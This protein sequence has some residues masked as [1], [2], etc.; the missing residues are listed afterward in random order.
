[1]NTPILVLKKKLSMANGFEPATLVLKNAN[2]VNVFTEEI[3]IGD[4]ALSGT[5]I[6]G[7]GDYQGIT[8]V[9]CT[10]K[11]ITPGFIDAHMHIESSM[12]TP[13][14]L[15]KAVLPSG[16]TTLIADPH[17]LVNVA[18]KN[19]LDY[20]V[21]STEHL[22]LNVYIML[23]S[24]VPATDFETNGAGQFT[25]RDM[26][27]YLNHPRILGLGEM[28]SFLNVIKGDAFILE[29]LSLCQDKICDGHAPGL[30]G[31]PLQA[32]ALAGVETDHESTSFDEVLEKLRTGFKILIR[33]GSAAKN[34]DA[35]VTGL[36]KQK[37]PLDHCLFCT[38]D[39]HLEDIHRDG[40]IRWNIEKAIDL[41][42]DPIKAIKIATIQAAQAYGLKRLGA[43]APGYRADLVI[44]SDLKSM[45]VDAVY[46]DGK[47]IDQLLKETPAYDTLDPRLLNS[48]HVK[49]L[50]PEKLNFPVKQKDHIIG[51][52]PFQINTDHLI[53]ALPQENGYFMPDDTYAKLCVIERHQN[54]G[55]VGIA[56]IKG[57]GIKNGAI[58]TT[59]A[60][61]SHNIIVVGSNDQDILAAVDHLEKIQG[62]YVIVS[63]GSVL[64]DVPLALAG[65][66]SLE[67]GDIVQKKLS[68]LITLARELGVPIGVDPF[69]TLSFMALPVIPRLRLTDLGLFDVDAFNFVETEG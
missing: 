68:T 35:I 2:I 21:E 63:N 61:D 6:V 37:L 17:E 28:M 43:I 47:P 66:I 13:L 51:I 39:K 38:D 16:T 26:I 48:V 7:T 11:F 25:A 18:G 1:M 20:V 30:T 56:P 46:K 19:G 64:G 23:P 3:I 5:T 41:G 24:S 45:T 65:L 29:K 42:L 34:L 55:N 12:V 15:A 8:E 59:V 10:G 53:E 32:Y 36:L 33:E 62:G 4:V 54:T 67:S 22:P 58:A 31:K 60:H 14:E 27:P 69:I 40:H 50:S 57:F 52:I 44:L 9:D 49:N